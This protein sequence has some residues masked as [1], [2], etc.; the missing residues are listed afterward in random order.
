MG[1]QRI[2]ENNN[3]NSQSRLST[4]YTPGAAAI[5][6]TTSGKQYS[7][8]RDEM[9]WIQNRY[10]QDGANT[11]GLDVADQQAKANGQLSAKMLSTYGN[12]NVDRQLADMG[13]PSEK[14][15]ESYMAAYQQ[16]HTGGMDQYFGQ[17]NLP[18]DYWTKAKGWYQADMQN[19]YENTT[20]DQQRKANG[21]MPSKWESKYTDTEID[22]QLRARGLP[23]LSEFQTYANRYNN[24]SGIETLYANAA[25]RQTQLKVNGILN[26][27]KAYKDPETGEEKLGKE[28]YIDAFYDELERTDDAGNYV[29]G[30]IMDKFKDSPKATTP[31]GDYAT[32]RANTITAANKAAASDDDYANYNAFSYDDFMSKADG[33]Y[34]KYWKDAKLKNGQIVSDAIAV[35]EREADAE[36]VK[37]YYSVNNGKEAVAL[38]DKYQKDYPDNSYEQMFLDMQANGVSDKD[39]YTAMRALQKEATKKN[40]S[41][42]KGYN[43]I[44]TAFNKAYGG[45]WSNVSD[46]VNGTEIPVRPVSDDERDAQAEKDRVNAAQQYGR[47][48]MN[49]DS[50]ALRIASDRV[51]FL[52]YDSP[53]AMTDALKADK[54]EDFVQAVRD[55]LAVYDSAM[56]AYKDAANTDAP[57][58]TAHEPVDKALK[59]LNALGFKSNYDAQRYVGG[60]REANPQKW[61]REQGDR[62]DAEVDA[63]IKKYGEDP[64][65]IDS[66]KSAIEDALF[67]EGNAPANVKVDAASALAVEYDDALTRQDRDALY[68]LTQDIRDLGFNNREELGDWLM[69]TKSSKK[70]TNPLNLDVDGVIKILDTVAADSWTNPTAM[71]IAL[72]DLGF[73]GDNFSGVADDLTYGWSDAD[74]QKLAYYLGGSK[75]TNRTY[76]D[77]IPGFNRA[78]GDTI[79]DTWAD[80]GIAQDKQKADPERFSLSLQWVQQ[81]V[82][83]GNMTE[84]EGYQLL[85]AKGYQ[86]E[87]EAYIPEEWHKAHFIENT[88][89]VL[90]AQESGPT[91]TTWEELSVEAQHR[92][93]QAAWNALSDEEKATMYREGWWEYDPSVYRTHGQALSQQIR[94]ILPGFITE[95]IKTP[96]T[97]ADAIGAQLTGRPEI[98]DTT[99]KLMAVQEGI[100]RLGAVSDNVNG[101]KIAAMATDAVQELLR[102]EV[103]GSI[104]GIVGEAFTDGTKIGGAIEKVAESTASPK[105]VRKA[106]DMFLGMVGSSPFMVSAFAGNYSEAKALGASNGEAAWYG[107]ITGMSEGIL[108]GFEF[109]QLWGKALGQNRFG[110]LLLDGKNTFLQE[111]GIVAQ[112]RL[113]SMAVSGLG[114]WTEE[115]I[116]YCLETFLKMRHSD[117]WGK[118]TEWSV[119]DWLEQAMMGFITGALGGGI[120]TLGSINK[121]TL[122]RDYAMSDKAVMKQ[123]FPDVFIANE[124]SETLPA[125]VLETYRNGGATV[126]SGEAYGG[127]LDAV[128][129]CL[130]SAKNRT[131]AFQETQAAEDLKLNNRLIEL[132]GYAAEVNSL[133]VNDS[134]SVSKFMNLCADKLG[135]RVDLNQP[136]RPQVQ[137]AFRARIDD[138]VKAHDTAIAAAQ[139]STES[140]LKQSENELKSLQKKIQEHYVGIYLLSERGIIYNDPNEVVSAV[141]K[142]YMD[143]AKYEPVEQASPEPEAAQTNSAEAEAAETIEEAKETAEAPENADAK[144]STNIRKLTDKEVANVQQAAKD[145]KYKGDIVFIDNPNEESAWIDDNGTITINRANISEAEA[146]ELADNPGWWLLKHEVA[147]FTEGTMAY[148][149]Y[150]GIV[151]RIIQ[152]RLGNRYGEAIAAIK[153]DYAQRGKTLDD[154]GAERELVAKFMGSGEILNNADTINAFVR[155]QGN[156]ADRIYNWIR[157]KI[158][159]LKLRRQPNSQLARDLLKAERLYAQAYREANK[160]P[161]RD[162]GANGRQY[163]LVGRT[164]DGRF[165]FRSNYPLGTEAK[166]KGDHIVK[167]VQDVW[168]KN[169][170]TLTIWNEDG[171]TTKVQSKFDSALPETETDQTDLGKI[172]YGNKAGNRSERRMTLDL[173]DDLYFI[174]ET[175]SYSRDMAPKEKE[176]NRA[177]EGETVY[178]YF[179][180]DI[181]YESYDGKEKTPVRMVIDVHEKPDGNYFHSFHVDTV[182]AG[183][184]KRIARQTINAAVVTPEGGN[185]SS[186]NN[187]TQPDGTVK[188]QLSTGDTWD[189]IVKKY[190]TPESAASE[191]TQNRANADAK[192]ESA[193]NQYGAIEPGREPR[194]RDVQVPK[195]TNDNNRVSQWIRSL[196]ESGKLTDDQAQNVLRMVVEQD[197]GTYVPT[198]QA[199]R[200]EEAR[201]YIAERQPLQA[202]QEF[203]DMIMQGKFGVKTNALG[204]QLLSDASARGDIAS[205]LD[206]AADLQLAATEAGQSAQIFN[207]LKELKGVG[208]AWYMQKIIDR[209]NSKYATEIKNGK[210]QKISVDPALM[211]DLAKA[212][213][214]DQIAKAEEAV[215]KD[216]ARQLPLTWADR[217]SSWRYF[218]MLANPTTHF[219]NI[220]GNVL[221][222]GLNATKDVVATGL[223]KMLNIDQGQRAH[224]VLTSADRSAWGGFADAS[225]NEQAR[226]LQGGGKL[227][228]ESFIKQNMRSFDTKW[229]NALAKFN[230]NALEGEDVAFIKPA[231]KNA[232]MQYMKAQGYTLNEQGQ[233]GK[234]DAKGEFHEISKADMNAAI[235]WASNQAWKATFRDA[236]SLA[237]L[238]NKISKENAV[239][240]LLVEGVMPFK[241]TPINIAKRGVEYSLA[242]IIMGIAQLANG[243]KKGKVTTAQA[244]DNLASGITGTALMALGVMLAKMGVIRAGGE[245]DKKLETFLEDTGDQTYAMKFG[246][247]SINMSSIAPATIP[248][249]MG[250]ALNEM[251]EQG[252]DSI[253]LST[254]T[255][256]IAGTLNPFME[257]S[258]MSSLNSALKNYNNN[259]IGG[260]LGNTLL[261]A[262]ENYG[263]QYLPTLGSKIAQF[264][265]PT[266][267]T[268]KSDATSKVGGNMDYYLRS[269]AKKV[270]GVEATLQPDVDVWGRTDTKDSFGDWALDFANKFILPT[271]IKVTNRDSVDNELIR[272]VESTGVTDFLPS[273][274][275]KYFTVNKVKYEM[276]AKQYSQYSQDRGQAAYAALKDVMAGAS[277]RN[278]SDEQKADMLKKAIDAAYKQ[279]NNQWKEKL[280][281]YNN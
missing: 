241:K 68:E 74:K 82:A 255:D 122:I 171:T 77:V 47:A 151:K 54:S 33:Y 204:L 247:K 48:I 90:Y 149:E 7:L 141:S 95:L 245:K 40:T 83:A 25:G 231:Y 111:L 5:V 23:P 205:V 170:I 78:E 139:A 52:G 98:W 96:V 266:R 31:T 14:N 127:V 44:S 162:N 70:E 30:N 193:V 45:V 72:Q 202:Q 49:G 196:I 240:R 220:T 150:A 246:D 58:A 35:K 242:G 9:N 261:T 110:K 29:Y 143:G 129:S 145:L 101:A 219:R 12:S 120:H 187:V 175:S 217:L 244:I 124:F 177:H 123:V 227:G 64:D 20:E 80:A 75:L 53:E 194:A 73:I 42:K 275:A 172:A 243:V 148:D 249:F 4:P 94:G 182:D 63:L 169:P 147:H 76:E 197:Y 238:L 27:D 92:F 56:V 254:I 155:E 154:M 189:E 89:P 268:T 195:Q 51:K 236:S 126:M 199:E 181:V 160:R 279:V 190:G 85:A 119:N 269:L 107:M 253:D 158:N 165:V 81:Q 112:A 251:I 213:T 87:M 125:G 229:L 228:F 109:D 116:G 277:Y 153:N 276:N 207:V 10:K 79:G 281:A 67:G 131:K 252:G 106:A 130:E 274:G 234:V 86:D 222:K 1:F 3:T 38:V 103:Y 16:W 138:A 100:G 211:A 248:L 200:M 32:D 184:Q 17:A 259:G 71:R 152:N 263:S 271:N 270:P 233:A 41:D 258:F 179:V 61:V 262:A 65:T 201:A 97:V 117:T 105:V 50:E 237:T 118:G 208:S 11:Y 104:G 267:R 142:A 66:T 278:A 84:E 18:E 39:A 166:V 174:A 59:A 55:A 225:Y 62:M 226:N 99:Q 223:E 210:M 108:E 265:D 19:A 93:A 280:G 178:H 156:L 21:L 146:K 114:E 192:V 257:M 136:I 161:S 239:S 135:I 60:A 203:H 167:L 2:D 13:L 206:I 57:Q 121:Q 218:S 183:N 69:G 176:S 185:D 15:L 188:S 159:D 140:A 134:D 91:A 191:Q 250:V 273:D 186:G 235:D 173:A 24:Y 157:Y 256:T 164:S 232:L 22:D 46:D 212:T 6:T 216:V 133:N 37:K 224:A 264:L 132:N 28:F 88:A 215:A 209:M 26:D 221:M 8:G 137:E 36:A 43:D 230:F 260:A 113:A 168:S 102:M 128:N 214:V 198:S 115:S 144:Q 272:V 163:A 34:D 180:N